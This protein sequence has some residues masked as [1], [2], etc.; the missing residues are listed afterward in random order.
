MQILPGGGYENGGDILYVDG[1]DGRGA[2]PYFESSLQMIGILDKVDRYDINGPS[3]S[4]ANHPGNRVRNVL[5]QLIPIYRKIIWNTGNLPITL[6]D[7]GPQPAK[8]DDWQMLFTFMDQ[9]TNPSGCGIY[10]SGDDLAESWAGLQGAS[11]SNFRDVYMPHRL[12]S[13]DHVPAHGLTP[14]VIGEDGGM[15]DHG[16]PL[17]EDTMVAYGGCPGINDF[18]VL[19]P[20]GSSQLQ[21]TYNGTGNATDGAV[22][23]FDSSNALGN[24]VRVVLSGF[25]YHYIR[26]DRPAGILDRADHL[27]DILRGLGSIVPNPVGGDT[28]VKFTN[29]LSQNY[30]NPFNPV[31]TISYSIKDRS[32]V[33]LK[34]YNVAG[35]LVRTL[36]NEQQAPRQ[37]GYTV[38]WRGVS[39]AGEPVSSGVYFYKLTAKNFTKTRKM[40]L[41]K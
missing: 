41:L 13:G 28:P 17:E 23:S 38:R 40:V 35:Q 15:F 36:V 30:P 8:S 39:N 26:D 11:A 2:Q 16:I 21:M 32:R 31:T 24:P 5:T 33:T 12:V 1:F 22:I 19:Q 14:L 25:S 34:I 7:A 18:D 29:D 37:E 3:S 20:I 27:V 6:S 9:H 4:V 10:L